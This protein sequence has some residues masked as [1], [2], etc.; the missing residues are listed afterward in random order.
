MT[1]IEV[2]CGQITWSNDTPEDQ[3]LAEIAQ[4]G[5]AGAP[6]GPPSGRTA[7]EIQA[8]YARHNLKPAPGYLGA[9]FWRA[10]QRDSILDRARQYAALMRELGCTELYVA[11]GGFNSHITSS[12]HSRSQ[13]AGHVAASDALSGA[14]Y[15]TFADTLNR[16]GEITLREGVRSCF[17][18]HVG[19]VIETREETDRL[20]SLTDPALVFLGPDTGH[21]A[22]AGADPVAFCRDY[23][24]RIKTIHVKDV[25]GAVRARG[26]AEEWDYGTFAKNG[27]F[28][29]L[30]EGDVDFP[31]IFAILRDAGFAGWV[32]AETDVTQKPTALESAT[33]SREYLRSMGL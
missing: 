19:S 30:G 8:L 6:A 20:L 14:E 29:E 3:V 1:T 17:H 23:A 18:N 28:A 10:D 15:Q 9:D 26:A 31:A 5:Y 12:G 33:I 7:A 22:W 11:A 24:T 32:I 2:G 4:A 25:D 16:V 27:I 13:L 21:L